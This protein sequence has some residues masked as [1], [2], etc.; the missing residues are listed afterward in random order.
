MGKIV[1]WWNEKCSIAVRR[2]RKA[3]K[4]LKRTH[5]WKNMIM[6]KKTQAET[7]TIIREV[8]KEYWRMFYIPQLRKCGI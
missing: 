8:K 5:N 6:Y 4:K 1:P 3:F 2:K 7:R